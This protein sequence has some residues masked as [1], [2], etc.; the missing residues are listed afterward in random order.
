MSVLARLWRFTV[1]LLRELSD[2]AAYMRHLQATGRPNSA[3][4]WRAFSDSRHRAKY[5]NA[6]CC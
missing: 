6:K 3:S 2:E 4:E 1:T 5:Q